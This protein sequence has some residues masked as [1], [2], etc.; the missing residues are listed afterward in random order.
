[1]TR[2]AF[3]LD[4]QVG[5]AVNDR[6][7]LERCLGRSPDIVAGRLPL[8]TYEG[9][10]SAASA[11]NAALRATACPVLVM[12]HQDVYL[13]AGSADR[14]MAAITEV[15]QHDPD[16]AVLGVIGIDRAG[17]LAGRTWSSGRQ[18][19]IGAGD[20]LPRQ[21]ATL[22]ELLLIVRQDIGPAFDERLPGFHLYAA[23]IVQIV[24]AMG[25]TAWIVDLPVVHNSRPVTNLGGGY[26]QAWRYM[27]HKYADCLPLPNL[28]C[29]IT[30]SAWP[31][32]KRDLRLRLHHGPWA[33]RGL[34]V[35]DPVDVA[36]RFG[37]E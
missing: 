24:R 28:V 19:L 30:K 36:R 4:L 3:T 33:G 25:R 11:C 20:D 7:T 37:W 22:D 35:D 8:T 14:L 12:A 13:P 2:N 17:Q 6:A 5:A 9:F 31:L 23:D 34:A 29:P 27:Q 1:M 26:T 15:R 16:W 21:A 32:R 18:T 10:A